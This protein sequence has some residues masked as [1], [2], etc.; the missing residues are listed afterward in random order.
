[1]IISS[2]LCILRA[3]DQTW[4]LLH[5]EN[6]LAFKLQCRVRV[7][8]KSF[9]LNPNEICWNWYRS[10]ASVSWIELSYVGK[11]HIKFLSKYKNEGRLLG[12]VNSENGSTTVI[13]QTI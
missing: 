8:R 7:I 1:M 6:N 4:K 10:S 11:S 9:L 2:K 3:T 12:K 13:V 5:G